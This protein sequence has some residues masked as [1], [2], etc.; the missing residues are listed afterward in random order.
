MTDLAI[1]LYDTSI[2]SLPD[3]L[4]IPPKAFAIWLEQ[5][6]GPLDFLLYLVKKNNFDI[7]TT[8]ILPITQQ[9]LTYIE[10]LK[11]SHFELA[12]DYLLMASTLIAIKSELLLPKPTPTLDEKS[13]TKALIRRLE[14]Y[15]QIKHAT[16]RLN[17][18]VRL[19]RDVFSAYASLPDP[20][21]RKQ[22]LP[23]Y[24][25]KL[26][27]H[28]FIKLQKNTRQTHR[29]IADTVPLAERLVAIIGYLSTKKCANFSDIL[30]KRQG[31]LGVVVSFMAILELIKQ[32]RLAVQCDDDN[33]PITLIWQG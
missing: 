9:Y 21:I 32:Q 19:E 28:A 16:H 25:T 2:Q 4:Y 14:D 31:K 17:A 26:L 30:D 24:P 23:P 8:A 12:G 22:H 1:R 5:F 10:Q 13:P 6:E 7:T 3:D 29:I 11:D 33:T 20:K 15:A 18:L 27:S